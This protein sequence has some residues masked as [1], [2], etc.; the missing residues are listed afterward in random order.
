[1]EGPIL[2]VNPGSSSIKLSLLGPDDVPYSEN[3]NNPEP[4][5]SR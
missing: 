3:S 5:A 2:A 1:M 4:T